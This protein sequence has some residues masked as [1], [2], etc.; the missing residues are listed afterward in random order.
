M[1]IQMIKLPFGLSLF[2]GNLD[3]FYFKQIKV[4]DNKIIN[5]FY[6]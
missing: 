3:K 5:H 2:F 4:I 1:I 6:I